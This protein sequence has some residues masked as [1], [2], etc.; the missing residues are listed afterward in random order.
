MADRKPIALDVVGRVMIEMG[1]DSARIEANGDRIVVTLPNFRSIAPTIRGWT[2]GRGRRESVRAIHDALIGAGLT[3]E[4]VVGRSTIGML[5]VAARP[6]FASRLFGFG[7]LEVR[8][9]GVFGSLARIRRR[10]E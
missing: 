5:G 3:L 8:M 6:G 2:R 7:P 10:R 9:G 1:G 4:V